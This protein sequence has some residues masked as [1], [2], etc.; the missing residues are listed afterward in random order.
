[1]V[2]EGRD[3][4]GSKISVTQKKMASLGL[5]KNEKGDF[6]YIDPSDK[7]KSKY[8]PVKKEPK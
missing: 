8:K 7:N 1:M 3:I 4:M 2:Y 5:M 6:E